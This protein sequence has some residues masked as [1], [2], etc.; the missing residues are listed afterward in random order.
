ML[1]IFYKMRLR[2][3]H[4]SFR[5]CVDSKMKRKI[6]DKIVLTSDKLSQLKHS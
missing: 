1:K 2:Y 3:L 4:I 5:D 6:N